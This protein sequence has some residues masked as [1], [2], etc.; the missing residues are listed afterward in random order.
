[1]SAVKPL[2]SIIIISYNTADITIDCLRSILSDKGLKNIPYEIIIVDNAS[3]D[4][5][6]LKIRKLIHSLKI[7][8]CKLKINSSNLGFAKANNQA[9]NFAKGNFFLLLNSDTIILHSA[10]SQSLNWLSS[11]PEASM[12]TARLLNRNHSIQAT[13][14]FFPNLA[15]IFTWSF[16]LDD[17]PFINYLIPPFHPHTPDFY[18][19]DSFFQ[20]SH[21]QDWITGAFMLIRAPL[22]RSVNGFDPDYF[23]Y[24]EEVELCYRLHLRYPDLR[25]WYLS[26]CQIIHLGGASSTKKIDPLFNEYRGV[27]SFFRKH[28]SLFH[29]RLARCFIR[30]NA[31]LRSIIFPSYRQICSQL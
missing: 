25:P 4:D 20:K 31:A 30:A 9:I 29:Y 10:I 8:N 27:L 5:S 1:M 28:T 21:P 2:L 12:C 19:H 7:D 26:D 23:M 6:V 16:G 14:G 11:H 24:S 3:A 13:G 18:T 15:N 22:F 17:L